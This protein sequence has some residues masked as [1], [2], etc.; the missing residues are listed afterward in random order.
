VQAGAAAGLKTVAVRYGYLGEGL[1]IEAWG[2]DV[3][4]DAPR[5]LLSLLA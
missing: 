5:D 4:I 3:V 1:P 2:A